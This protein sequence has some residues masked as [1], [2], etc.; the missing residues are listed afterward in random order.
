MAAKPKY[1][2]GKNWRARQLKGGQWAIEVR[3]TEWGKDYKKLNPA[4]TEPIDVEHEAHK[5]LRLLSS[6]DAQHFDR[7]VTRVDRP[8]SIN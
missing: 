5:M 6:E 8:A 2:K 1:L 3:S 7:L 4:I